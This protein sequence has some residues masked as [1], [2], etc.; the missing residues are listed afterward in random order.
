MPLPRPSHLALGWPRHRS[1]PQPRPRAMLARFTAAAA[2]AAALGAYGP[3]GLPRA[4]CRQ[5]APAA[6]VKVPQ[7]HVGAAIRPEPAQ[8]DE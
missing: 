3:Y 8:G 4:A 1:R 2:A 6:A 5:E 7:S